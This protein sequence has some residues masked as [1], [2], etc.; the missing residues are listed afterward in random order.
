VQDERRVHFVFLY[1]DFIGV[2]QRLEL[3]VPS[4]EVDQFLSIVRSK[5]DTRVEELVY[6]ITDSKTIER[7]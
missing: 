5:L 2:H 3:A 1:Q 4:I 6:E 7:E